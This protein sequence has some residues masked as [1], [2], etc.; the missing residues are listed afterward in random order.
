[1]NTARMILLMNSVSILALYHTVREIPR[2]PPHGVF[3][4]IPKVQP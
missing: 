3:P 4:A 1:M 2:H